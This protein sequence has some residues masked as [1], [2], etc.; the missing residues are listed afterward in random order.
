ME[1]SP[2]GHEV[3][4]ANLLDAGTAWQSRVLEVAGLPC[5]CPLLGFV[6]VLHM[7]WTHS[8][9]GNVQCQASCLEMCVM[10]CLLTTACFQLSSNPGRENEGKNVRGHLRA[11][12]LGE[13]WR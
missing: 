6:A 12:P 9:F 5:P 13:R 11:A 7:G 10:I 3:G 2:Q 4:H 1:Q 8:F